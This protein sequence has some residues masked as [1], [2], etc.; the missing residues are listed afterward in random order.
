MNA[1]FRHF[2]CIT[3]RDFLV[4]IIARGH[5]HFNGLEFSLS[6]LSVYV[7]WL[8]L[9]P[10]KTD[11]ILFTLRVFVLLQ[12]WL[13]KFLNWIKFLVVILRANMVRDYSLIPLVIFLSCDANNVPDIIRII[14]QLLVIVALKC[15]RDLKI[16]TL[17][18]HWTLRRAVWILRVLWDQR[19]PN[20]RQIC[21]VGE[22]IDE[23]NRR[24]NECD[25]S[26]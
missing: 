12:W 14:L 10:V 19:A 22:S 17:E 11:K 5:N 15:K 3:S 6:F 21:H 24:A 23:Y 26:T 25:R 20:G 2:K 13:L 18:V 9:W 1:I 7:K 8:I 4:D 16:T